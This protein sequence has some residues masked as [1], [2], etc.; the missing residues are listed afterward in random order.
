MLEKNLRRLRRK[1]K[2]RSRI[3]GTAECPRLSVFRSNSNIYA[4]L[5]NDN[6]NL[7]IV[8]FSDLKLERTVTK[9]ESAKK[10]GQELAKLAVSKDIKAVVF[11][12]NGFAY[13]GRVK[14]LA[15]AA[16]EAGLEF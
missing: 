6:E 15:D 2:V 8:S 5:I 3:H 10:V 7:T 16:R 12:R 13:H 11:D 9:T 1:I 4:Q 14:A